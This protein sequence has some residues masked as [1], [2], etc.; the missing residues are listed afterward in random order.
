MATKKR[1]SITVD[2]DTVRDIELTARTLGMT[3]AAYIRMCV[4][5]RADLIR[6]NSNLRTRLMDATTAR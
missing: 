3:P 4:E 1:Y 5:E 2:A 6:K